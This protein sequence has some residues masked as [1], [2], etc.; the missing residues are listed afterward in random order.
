MS[1]I[2]TWPCMIF[3]C[4]IYTNCPKKNN[5]KSLRTWFF[6]FD[7]SLA[8]ARRVLTENK[9]FLFWLTLQVADVWICQQGL[10]SANE[11]CPET[12]SDLSPRSCWGA[13]SDEF[14]GVEKTY[15]VH[16]GS[17]KISAC[18]SKATTF[19]DISSFTE[20]WLLP[21]KEIS[22]LFIRHND[23][24]HHRIKSSPMSRIYVTES[25]RHV[26]QRTPR[27][28]R[29]S[30][31]LGSQLEVHIDSQAR[32]LAQQATKNAEVS[33]IWRYLKCEIREIPLWLRT[34]VWPT[35]LLLHSSYNR[36]ADFSVDRLLERKRSTRELSIWFL[37]F[38]CWSQPWKPTV[39][40]GVKDL[41]CKS[42]LMKYTTV[43]G[44]ILPLLLREKHQFFSSMQNS[45]LYTF[46]M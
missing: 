24:S 21:G 5:S 32:L 14:W 46:V 40:S 8:I 42:N 4:C 7:T 12:Y 29:I 43:S 18:E 27:L 30:A 17:G 20:A 16:N 33:A 19:G 28:C 38:R 6:C 34:G 45:L 13:G 36:R 22:L 23:V 35:T 26:A 3:A 11:T 37:M 1:T 41:S 10:K 15:P 31:T 44:Q 2:E 9:Q 39:T 25:L